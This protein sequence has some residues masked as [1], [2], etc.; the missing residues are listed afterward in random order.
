MPQII[1]LYQLVEGVADKSFGKQDPTPHAL[2]DTQL[3]KTLC[4]FSAPVHATAAATL[5][6]QDC[7]G[8][9]LLTGKGLYITPLPFCC[10]MQQVLLLIT[11]D[12]FTQSVH[13][14]TVCMSSSH[15]LAK[16]PGNWRR[17]ALAKYAG[18]NLHAVAFSLSSV[19]AFQAAGSRICCSQQREVQGAML[20]LDSIRRMM[21][22][23]WQGLQQFFCDA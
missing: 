16:L 4:S 23:V 18:F 2:E 19:W 15:H 9:W 5:L 3:C 6:A 21:G 13:Q 20:P 7:S 1:F 8:K 11:G 10:Q 22:Q 17:T 14:G 12:A